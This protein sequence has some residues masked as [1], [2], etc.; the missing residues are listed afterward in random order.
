MA[1]RHGFFA[2]ERLAVTEN[3]PPPSSTV[4]FRNLRDGVW[5]VILTQ[6]DNVFNFRL[7]P[8]NPLGATF[9]PVAFF[10]TTR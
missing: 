10:G 5:D 6:S 1:E 9:E 8:S 2:A 4:I 7:N 3:R